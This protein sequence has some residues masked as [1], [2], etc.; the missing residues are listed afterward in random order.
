M[1]PKLRTLIRKRDRLHTKAKRVN[2]QDT[3]TK[4]RDLRNKVISEIRDAKE[5][6]E[7][8]SAAYIRD[9]A[10]GN[11][12]IW[13][14]IVKEFYKGNASTKNL[15][16]PL[17]VNGNLIESD[18]EKAN[19]L[20]DFFVE[21]TRIDASNTHLPYTH[22]LCKEQILTI[23]VTARTVK[24]LLKIL[25]TSKASGPDNISPKLL[26]MTADTIA[27]ILAKIFNFSLRSGIFPDI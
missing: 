13:W 23:N 6:E 26:K 20:N 9:N 2:N 17:L 19:A 22:P 14:R 7:T 24:E 18:S 4:Y 1:T 3:W 8:R 27:P 16:Q 10:N 25:N 15:G 5:A 12:K 11:P 21:Q